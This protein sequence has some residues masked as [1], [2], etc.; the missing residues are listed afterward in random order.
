[1]PAIVNSEVENFTRYYGKDTANIFIDSEGIY[2]VRM[3]RVSGETLDSLPPTRYLR[4]Q[5]KNMS[6][7]WRSLMP[8]AFFMMTSIPIT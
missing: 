2:H 8:T 3:Y 6:T 1:M 5:L 4:M 7:C